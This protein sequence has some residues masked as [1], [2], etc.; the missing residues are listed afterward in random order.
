MPEKQPTKLHAFAPTDIGQNSAE[1]YN[2]LPTRETLKEHTM[3]QKGSRTHN[4]KV[5]S[6][7]VQDRR[8]DHG[9]RQAGESLD[10]ALLGPLRNTECRL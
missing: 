3:A 7:Q 9:T 8:S 6:T 2:L 10:I 4:L 1:A 5:S